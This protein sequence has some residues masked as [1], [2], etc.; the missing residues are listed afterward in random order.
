MRRYEIELENYV[1]KLQIESR[2]IGDLALNHIVSTVV[3]YQFKLAQTARSL[4]DLEMLEEAEPI[5]EIIRT[6]LRTLW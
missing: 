4:T 6:F 3:K 2:V 5:K 1:K